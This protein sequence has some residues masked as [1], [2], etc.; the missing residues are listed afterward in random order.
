MLNRY[1]S[2][3][4]VYKIIYEDNGTTKSI[5]GNIIDEEEHVYIVNAVISNDIIFIGKRGIIKI[6]PVRDYQ[7]ESGDEYG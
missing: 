6:S 5:K 4:F 7:P 3:E 1:L 2:T